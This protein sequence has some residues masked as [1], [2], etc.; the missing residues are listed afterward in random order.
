M[1]TKSKHTELSRII[2]VVDEYNHEIR[3]IDAKTGHTIDSLK[4]EDQVLSW[5]QIDK[6]AL[7]VQYHWFHMD[8]KLPRI[9]MFTDDG[10]LSEIRVNIPSVLE[11]DNVHAYHIYGMPALSLGIMGF[12]NSFIF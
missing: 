4:S 11:N 10:K 5:V 7:L 9:V 6:N 2:I 8:V 12:Y 3:S 1:E